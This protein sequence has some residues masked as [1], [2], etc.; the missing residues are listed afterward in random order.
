MKQNNKIKEGRKI[1]KEEGGGREVQ[2]RGKSV[3]V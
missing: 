3:K 1:G 2:K